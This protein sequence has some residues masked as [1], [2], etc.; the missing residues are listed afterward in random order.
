VSYRWHRRTV[1]RSFQTKILCN[2]RPWIPSIFLHTPNITIG[3]SLKCYRIAKLMSCNSSGWWHWRWNLY[4]SIGVLWNELTKK[5]TCKASQIISSPMESHNGD[6]SFVRWNHLSAKAA[7]PNL[8]ARTTQI[9]IPTNLFQVLTNNT[10]DYTAQERW[11]TPK[12]FANH[13]R[14]K[15][16]LNGPHC[17]PCVM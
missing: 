7:V 4:I 8:C 3:S 5:K 14:M 9:T 10:K 17:L 15:S 2:F 12:L 13:T 6:F 11:P 1:N 16:P